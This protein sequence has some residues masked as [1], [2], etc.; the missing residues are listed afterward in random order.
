MVPRP[1]QET[2]RGVQR[3]YAAQVLFRDAPAHTRLR[4]ALARAF[5]PRVVVGLA[6]LI[7]RLVDES[8]DAVATRGQMDVIADLA[9]PLP[10]SVIAALLG[11]P[12]QDMPQLKAWSSDMGATYAQDIS[13]PLRLAR[14]SRRCGSARLYGC[15]GHPAPPRAAG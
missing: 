10:T 11:L 7:Q 15:R 4:R 8:L 2:V 3:A 6:P 13:R 9:Y 5:T 1:L 14:L 12:R